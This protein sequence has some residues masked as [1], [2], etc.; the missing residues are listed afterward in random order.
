[1]AADVNPGQWGIVF[2]LPREFDTLRWVRDAA[3]SWYPADHIGRP[4]GTAQ[5][6]P[7]AR[8]TV[9]EPRVALQT[10]WSLDAHALGTNDFRST[11]AQIREASL[12][13]ASG[14]TWKVVS[15]DASQSVRAW[16]EGDRVRVLVA[17]FNTGGYDQFFA[18]HYSAERRP[19]KKGD[20]VASSFRLVM[21]AHGK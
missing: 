6:N 16:V 9:E 21:S 19:L 7:V 18:T 3:W 2:T 5:A 14:R 8:R 15:A 17:G 1:V 13:A 10:P 20:V 11:K 4:E 12:S